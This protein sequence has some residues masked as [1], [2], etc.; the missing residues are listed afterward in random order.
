MGMRTGIVALEKV[1][2]FVANIFRIAAYLK[3]FIYSVKWPE[4]ELMHQ[5]G[6]NG[7]GWYWD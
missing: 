5:A 4:V 2:D 6:V 7:L 3:V 1:V